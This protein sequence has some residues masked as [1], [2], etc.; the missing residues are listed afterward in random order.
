MKFHARPTLAAVLAAGF[1]IAAPNFASAE[2]D[3]PAQDHSDARG[4]H[5]AGRHH[6][7]HPGGPFLRELKL[8][9]LSDAQRGSIRTAIRSSFEAERGPHEATRSL[10]R[11]MLTTPPDSAGYAALVNQL[12][13]A[14]ADAARDRVQRLAALKA[15][16]YAMLTDAQKARL[17]EKL[18]NLPE[19]P[20][21]GEKT[22]WKPR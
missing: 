20:A 14:E 8:L 21:R 22:G 5:G 10:H 16:I 11:A 2:G 18:R 13:D 7:R 15:E 1:L 4:E 17:T 6:G 12:A 19:P 9:D 3:V